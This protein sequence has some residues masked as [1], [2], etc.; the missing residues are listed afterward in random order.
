MFEEFPF[1]GDLKAFNKLKLQPTLKQRIDEMF[2]TRYR[3]CP[4]EPKTQSATAPFGHCRQEQFDRPSNRWV[5]CFENKQHL[6]RFMMQWVLVCSPRL[7]RNAFLLYERIFHDQY[8]CLQLSMP[9]V[10]LIPQGL[11]CKKHKEPL[12]HQVHGMQNGMS[13]ANQR[14][15]LGRWLG[16]SVR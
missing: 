11:A 1:Q 4:F 16:I 10:L 2:Y 12:R 3:I 6:L 5:P 9:S 13:L 7:R 14:T 8:L 15:G